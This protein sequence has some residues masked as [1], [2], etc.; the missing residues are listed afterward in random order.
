M[1]DNQGSI[2]S[3]KRKIQEDANTALKAGEKFQ[4][5]V[6]RLALSS[7]KQYEVDN[8]KELDNDH[9]FS[10]LEKMVKQRQEAIALFKEGGRMDIAEKESKEIEILKRYLPEPLDES[11]IN[12]LVNEIIIDLDANSLKDMGKVMK[13]I[14]VRAK[15]RVDMKLVSEKIKNILK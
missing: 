4:L 5:G 9:A 13:E 10:I 7:I 6:L 3:I 12:K 2:S 15:G 11:L 8:R 1:N 14:Q